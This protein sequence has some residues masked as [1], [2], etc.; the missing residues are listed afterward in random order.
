MMPCPDWLL[1]FLPLLPCLLGCPPAHPA[2][3]V[4][5]K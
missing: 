5:P 2:F 3:A 1:L 4:T